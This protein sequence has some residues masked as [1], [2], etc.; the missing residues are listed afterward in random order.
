MCNTATQ[1][2]HS[3]SKSWQAPLDAWLGSFCSN[4]SRFT[5]SKALL[6]PLNI[7]KTCLYYSYSVPREYCLQRNLWHD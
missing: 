1:I 7:P 3:Y 2:I 6:K 4:M 5:V